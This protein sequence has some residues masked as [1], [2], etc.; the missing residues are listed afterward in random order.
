MSAVRRL[1]NAC[2]FGHFHSA[3][4]ALSRCSQEEFAIVA[5]SSTWFTTQRGRLTTPGG[6][7]CPSRECSTMPASCEELLSAVGIEPTTY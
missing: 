4:N 2:D 1:T 5:M 7:Q 3:G 6:Q